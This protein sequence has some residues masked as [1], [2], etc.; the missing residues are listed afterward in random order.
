M[1]G[2]VAIVS[3]NIFTDG[4]KIEQDLKS[5]TSM[6]IHRGP[7][8]QGFFQ[9]DWLA[10]GFNRLA[11]IDINKRSNQP[12]VDENGEFVL[13]YNGE[14]Y[15]YIDI[16]EELVSLGHKFNTSSDSEVV[17]KSFIQ[18]GEKCIEKFQGMF[19]FIVAELSTKRLFI[20]R[21]Q[22]GIKPLYY[23]ETE[24]CYVFTSEIKALRL[25][26]RFSVNSNAIYEYLVFRYSIEDETLFKN[27]YRLQPG[28]FIKYQ[29]RSKLIIK[30]YFKVE[31]L[32]KPPKQLKDELKEIE[33]ILSHSTMLH[34]KSDV[35][36]GTQLSGGVDSSLITK[37]VSD[38]CENKLHTFSVSFD[39]KIHDESK[40]QKEVSEMTNSTH[41][42]LLL[43]ED[44]FTDN[45]EKCIWHGDFP[46]HDANNVPFYLLCKM[47]RDHGIKVLLSGDGADEICQG[48]SRHIGLG[49]YAKTLKSKL[50]TAY[51]NSIIPGILEIL[52][53]GKLPQRYT[54]FHP[55]IHRSVL[56]SPHLAKKLVPNMKKT[57]S[58]RKSLY[59]KM[60]KNPEAALAIQDFN[61][62]LR[63]WLTRGDRMAMAASVE[64]RVPFCNM[65]FAEKMSS[66]PFE[67][68]LK[69]DIPK[70]PLK[71][72]AAQYFSKDL[73]WRKKVGFGLPLDKWFRNKKGL[74]RYLDLLL[75]KRTLQ[76][77]L[78]DSKVLKRIIDD[79]LQEKQNY[80][81]FLWNILNL[82]LWHRIFIDTDK[83]NGNMR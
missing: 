43:T 61:G 1:C 70:Y 17:L 58:K 51:A 54:D 78:F 24:D 41:H 82:E 20:C 29:P 12:L 77:E 37:Y 45:I 39:D 55:I 68:K 44:M 30:Q 67:Y 73:V 38:L 35:E 7:D 59:K 2:F 28:S 10:L 74:G 80:G 8:A 52:F 27:V 48:Y 4:S 50:R 36:Y 11:I 22:F 65:K 47:A 13:I 23:T 16:K 34:T 14:I 6:L 21:D 56:N 64:I 63:P 66:L 72:I 62:Y 81:M 49:S 69:N 75:E 76:R 46:L 9:N 71:K 79:H 83:S 32:F 33:D 60:K 31:E 15:N 25:I 53:L 26:M 3:K 40:Y 18:W 5:M 57:F 19:S 42:N